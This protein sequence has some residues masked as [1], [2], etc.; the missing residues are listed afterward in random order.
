MTKAVKWIH[1]SEPKGVL[2]SLIPVEQPIMSFPGACRLE[3][4]SQAELKWFG[5]VIYKH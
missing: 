3:N 5:Y 2:F 1:V 4:Q